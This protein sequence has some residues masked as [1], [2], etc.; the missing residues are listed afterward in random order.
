MASP[1]STQRSVNPHAASRA[2]GRSAPCGWYPKLI[3]CDCDVQGLRRP[4]RHIDGVVGFHP[5]C[6]CH[7]STPSNV[8]PRRS[9]Y[10]EQ[11]CRWIP[12]GRLVRDTARRVD[13]E[14]PR[15]YRRAWHTACAHPR[16]TTCPAAA[17]AIPTPA[18]TSMGSPHMGQGTLRPQAS[19]ASIWPSP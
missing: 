14:G 10:G 8:D 18:S 7:R 11:A 5:S 1:D 16:S 15:L 2:G 12:I 17:L 9:Q 6:R 4:T 13:Y 3:S 19:R